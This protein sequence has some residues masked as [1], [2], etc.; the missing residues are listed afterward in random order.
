MEMRGKEGREREKGERKREKGERE[1]GKEKGKEE[2]KGGK[3]KR[4]GTNEDVV[5]EKGKEQTRMSWLHGQLAPWVARGW[6]QWPLFPP[7]RMAGTAN[8]PE[9]TLRFWVDFERG[10]ELNFPGM[11]T[12]QVGWCL[13]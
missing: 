12:C 9:G 3:G 1:R 13:L 8:A 6:E 7:I 2:K 5:L 11:L 4:E 10:L